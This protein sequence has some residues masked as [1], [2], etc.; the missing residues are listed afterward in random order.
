MPTHRVGATAVRTT[1]WCGQPDGGYTALRSAD[2][3]YTSRRKNTMDD[4]V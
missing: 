1:S 3:P 2:P 4:T